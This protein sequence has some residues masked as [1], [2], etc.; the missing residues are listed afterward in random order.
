MRHEHRASNPKK[1]AGVI[2]PPPGTHDTPPINFGCN[3]R[4]WQWFKATLPRLS[5]NPIETSSCCHLCR[6]PSEPGSEGAMWLSSHLQSESHFL[7]ITLALLLLLR[8][9]V[10]LRLPTATLYRPGAIGFHSVVPIWTRT[11]PRARPAY[12]DVNS[13]KSYMNSQVPLLASQAHS[14]NGTSRFHTAG[15]KR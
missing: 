3:A 7:L 13:Y 14:I 10:S 5:G 12:T 11:R 4:E 8:L 6:G 1:C 2:S 9:A 15:I